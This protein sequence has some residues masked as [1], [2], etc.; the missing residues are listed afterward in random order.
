MTEFC[1]HITPQHLLLAQLLSNTTATSYTTFNNTHFNVESLCRIHKALF[2]NTEHDFHAGRLR[3]LG[4]HA[5][6]IEFPLAYQVK[7][8][9]QQTFIDLP[10]P[11][12]IIDWTTFVLSYIHPFF[13]GNRRTCWQFCN[14]FLQDNGLKPIDW[15]AIRP[16]WESTLFYSEAQKIECLLNHLIDIK[17]PK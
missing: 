10:H 15:D 8:L 3:T 5:G 7:A 6:S 13:D 4:V 1:P 9:L 16:F 2:A 17:T 12:C 11:L 14:I